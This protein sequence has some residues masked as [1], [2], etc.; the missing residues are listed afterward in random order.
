MLH[1]PKAPR[2]H[3]LSG[4]DEDIGQNDGE[5]VKVGLLAQLVEQKTFNLL[6]Q[7][8]SPWRPTTEALLRRVL[9][10]GN[11]VQE[12]SD[13]GL[14]AEIEK[15]EVPARINGGTGPSPA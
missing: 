7:G 9:L 6:V 8:S 12:W 15:C 1:L 10:S 4:A 5:D 2:S 14:A 13:R 11:V 3:P